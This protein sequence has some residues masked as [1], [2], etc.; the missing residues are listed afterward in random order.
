[1]DFLS[2]SYMSA[3]KRCK[4]VMSWLLIIHRYVYREVILELLDNCLS[5]PAGEGWALCINCFCIC[6]DPAVRLQTHKLID[7]KQS[8]PRSQNILVWSLLLSTHSLH[9]H[10]CKCSLS[11]VKG[12]FWKQNKLDTWNLKHWT[13]SPQ[14]DIWN[15][16]EAHITSSLSLVTT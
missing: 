1:M 11:C 4:I 10:F 12:P 8:T 5:W 14:Q 7:H 16:Y 6:L 9:L 13:L 15:I 2:F 3:W